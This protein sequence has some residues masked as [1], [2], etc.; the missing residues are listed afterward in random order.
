MKKNKTLANIKKELKNINIKL[1]NIEDKIPEK[2]QETKKQS[3]YDNQC[4]W[5][6]DI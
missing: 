5:Y 2:Q 1:Q 3:P 6:K 4:W